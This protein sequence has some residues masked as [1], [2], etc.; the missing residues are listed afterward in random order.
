MAKSGLPP[1]PLPP[2]KVN[3]F[4]KTSIALN[5]SKRFLVIP[6]ATVIF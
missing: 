1:P 5:F 2:N 4:F 6:T 3:K